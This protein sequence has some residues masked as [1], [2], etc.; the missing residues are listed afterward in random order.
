MRNSIVMNNAKAKLAMC[1]N[2]AQSQVELAAVICKTNC[3]SSAFRAGFHRYV[4]WVWHALVC[5]NSAIN[6]VQ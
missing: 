6:T 2:F 5:P 4:G 1:F 3:D